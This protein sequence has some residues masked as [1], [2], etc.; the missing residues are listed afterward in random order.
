MKIAKGLMMHGTEFETWETWAETREQGFVGGQERSRWN[1]NQNH[2]EI[3][4]HPSPD[5]YLSSRKH[6][7]PIVAIFEGGAVVVWMRIVPYRLMYGTLGLQ[8]VV[9]VG[10]VMV[11]LGGGALLEVSLG[12]SFESLQLH[13]TSCLFSLLPVY[14]WKCDQPA[15]C[16]CCPAMPSP[17][18]WMLAL[19]NCKPK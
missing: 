18:L 8:L 11:P 16:P 14:G 9:L 10:E 1:V 12:V 6:M 13:P 7:M 2:I 19:W 3:P 17:L 4:S 5:G 15:S